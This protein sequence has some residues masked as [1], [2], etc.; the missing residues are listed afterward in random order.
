MGD[1]TGRL[2]AI[3]EVM[4]E[5]RT[6]GDDGFALGFAGDTYNTAVYAAREIGVPGAVAY[7]T[8]V[9]SEPLSAALVERA[10]GE[11]IDTTHVAV[12][13]DRNIGIYSVSTDAHGERSFHYWRADSAARRLFAVEETAMFMPGAEII[14]LSGITLA[15]LAPAARHRLVEAL[16]ARRAAGTRIAFDSNYR[17]KLWEDAAAARAAMQALWEVTDIALPSIDDEMELFGDSGEAAV[18]DRFAERS[19]EGIAIKRGIRGPV[20]PHLDAAAH[21]DFPPADRVVDTTAAGDSFNGG[22]LAAFLAGKDEAARLAAGHALAARV[23][24]APGAIIPREA[25]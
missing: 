5:I 10:A 20:S 17:P 9:G 18:I 7:L 19:W 13:P 25:G 11:G 6:A 1:A 12:D 21:P 24:G 23:V 4:A 3:G 2:L 15:I 16:A 22:Y 8:R 14:Y